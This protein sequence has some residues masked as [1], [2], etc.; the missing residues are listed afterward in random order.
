MA[1]KALGQSDPSILEVVISREPLMLKCQK[2][3]NKSNKYN[4]NI[5]AIFFCQKVPQIYSKRGKN[6]RGS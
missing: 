4:E 3:P 1:R 5:F 2:I 6:G